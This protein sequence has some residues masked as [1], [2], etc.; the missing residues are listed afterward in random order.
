MSERGQL[1]SKERWDGSQI[2]VPSPHTE[3]DLGGMQ[4]SA[5]SPQTA[6]VLASL[7]FSA[8]FSASQT[9]ERPRYN[10]SPTPSRI[11]CHWLHMRNN[12]TSSE[13]RLQKRGGF[14]IKIVVKKRGKRAIKRQK[15]LSVSL[16]GH[17]LWGGLWIC[18]LSLCQRC[19]GR[20]GEARPGF[21][22]PNCPNPL[23]HSFFPPLIPFT[24]LKR[25]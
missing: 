7:S 13:T 8:L 10:A 5:R 12:E 23:Y 21:W 2:P 1:P 19:K 4:E 3:S 11:S 22:L 18:C 15:L 14:N 17:Y 20:P 6:I 16:C 24:V 25:A 9:G